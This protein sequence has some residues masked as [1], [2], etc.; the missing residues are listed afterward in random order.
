MLSLA[1]V[2]KKYGGGFALENIDLKVGNGEV[3]FITG[4]SGSGKTTLLKI[5]SSEVL[6]DCGEVLFNDLNIVKFNSKEVLNYRKNIGVVYQDFRVVNDKTV[7]ENLEMILAVRNTP[8]TSWEKAVDEILKKV[9][10]SGMQNHFP[11]ELSGGELQRVAIARALIGEPKLILADEPTGNL[12]WDTGWEVVR[13]LMEN[14]DKATSVI[15][16]SHNLDIVKRAKHKV[17]EL[18]EGKIIK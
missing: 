10:L 1:K 12:D 18:K 6:P 13:L 16:T 2:S 7:R 8:K 3:V 15:I 11:A 9:M 14:K 17:I 4:P 5:V